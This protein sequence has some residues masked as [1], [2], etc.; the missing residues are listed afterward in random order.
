V[1]TYRFQI[2]LECPQCG[3]PVRLDEQDHVVQ[4]GFCRTRHILHAEPYP[5]YYIP[6]RKKAYAHL[7][8][9]Y[10]P[11]WRFKG[12]E[13]TLGVHKPAFKVIDQSICALNHKHLPLSLGF[14]TQTQPLKCMDEKLSGH[15]LPPEM[16]YKQIFRQLS[17]QSEKKVHIGE[18]L[19]L[20]FMPFYQDKESMIDG[21][22]G[23][24]LPSFT[25]PSLTNL[26]M[27]KIRHE[28]TP[29][30]CPNCGWRLKG[31]TTSVV[32]P[33][34]HCD[35]FFLM[36]QKKLRQI[37]VLTDTASEKT[38]RMM[39][40]WRFEIQTSQ[41]DLTTRADLVKLANLPRVPTEKEKSS[42]LHFYVPAFKINPKLFLRIG[43][44]VT[45]SQMPWSAEHP[46]PESTVHPADL[47]I[48]EGFQAIFPLIMELSA[49][50]QAT[51]AA[52]KTERLKLK[53]FSLAYL[54]FRKSGSELIQDTLGT[55]LPASAVRFG[56][57]L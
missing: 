47:S 37:S 31:E 14:R 46:M 34:T 50:R 48:E 26:T 2:D 11:Y 28:F 21:V 8:S 9:I 13:F 53:S 17:G 57:Q 38:D 19:Y 12:L 51:W 39:P 23:K 40:F 54:G 43:R 42:R 30:L 5:C 10:I 1:N 49:R 45:V 52:L 7:T 18:I 16:S 15:C 33:C 35:R 4:C 6:P 29:G 32:L 44:Q 36:H 56:R 55:S 41:L 22:S 25:P 20:I 24:V 3:A 27:P